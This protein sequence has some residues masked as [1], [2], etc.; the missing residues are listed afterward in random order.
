MYISEK[1]FRRPAISRLIF[2]ILLALALVLNA[3]PA[4]VKAAVPTKVMVGTYDV[5]T[6][7]ETE[8]TLYGGKVT[9]K[10]TEG[11]A[12]L[13]LDGVTIPA[14]EQHYIAYTESYAAIYTDGELTIELVGANFATAPDI[15]V[16][17]SYGIFSEGH[18][19]VKSTAIGGSLV[20]AGGDCSGYSIGVYTVKS[21][22]VS[23]EVSLTG[24]S[25]SADNSYGICSDP[26]YGI[27]VAGGAVLTGNGGDAQ[28]YN[29]GVNS[30]GNLVV[31]DDSRVVGNCATSQFE[32]YGISCYNINISGGACVS[33]YGGI[34]D[35]ASYGVFIKPN[36]AVSI[37]G[38][39]ELTGVGKDADYSYG[40]YC[41]NYTTVNISDNGK[42]NG[43][44]GA[45][46]RNSYGVY[47]DGI[48]I[49]EDNAS[50]IGFGGTVE[51]YSA[52]I[53]IEDT[54]TVNGDA[55]LTGIGGEATGSEED[56]AAYLLAAVTPPVFDPNL[57]SYSSGI[58]C[59]DLNITGGVVT[60]EGGRA[61]YSFGMQPDELNF[62]GGSLTAKGGP[63]YHTSCGIEGWENLSLSGGEIY[64]EGK[65]AEASDGESYGIYMQSG[66]LLSMT[67][68]TF[69]AVS[70]EGGRAV[71]SNVFEVRPAAG[72]N[73]S[74]RVSDEEVTD[75]LGIEVYSVISNPFAYDFQSDTPVKESRNVRIAQVYEVSGKVIKLDGDPIEGA[76]VNVTG[77]APIT[78]PATGEYSF[79]LENGTYEI[80]AEKAGYESGELEVTVADAAVTDADI[81]LAFLYDL[82]GGGTHIK[83]IDKEGLVFTSN[84]EYEDFDN[85]VEVDGVEIPDEAFN[86]EPGS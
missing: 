81:A 66:H 12:V 46:E 80:T 55:I 16:G 65:Q 31:A 85:K 52:G 61:H 17:N 44:G 82:E 37:T 7:Y 32:S 26:D 49:L 23:G 5:T 42:L 63:A 36:G 86:D 38:T 33:G 40:V 15:T 69:T 30:N 14:G 72:E 28:T 64:A 8:Q 18:L 74:I 41:D 43:T 6:G 21:L 47:A 29:C 22:T 73:F 25:G 84:G 78:T 68:G 48:T 34:G 70:A 58:Y 19:T 53:Y 2:S 50:L 3:F 60:G 56:I 24:N 59:Y 27:T 57:T 77:Y 35:D 45:A 75:W 83:Q 39:G 1:V 54:I 11:V 13:T 51:F 10:V 62:S 67:D 9:Y 20:A 76:Q 79:I 4:P 71:R